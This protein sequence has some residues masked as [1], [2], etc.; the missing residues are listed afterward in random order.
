M[1]FFLKIDR[2]F[3]ILLSLRD[4]LDSSLSSSFKKNDGGKPIKRKIKSKKIIFRKPKFKSIIFLKNRDNVG[5][6]KLIILSKKKNDF[7]KFKSAN[8]PQNRDNAVIAI[9]TNIITVVISFISGNLTSDNKNL[10]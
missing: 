2:P 10:R 9:E 5:K 6:I 1:V 4:N 3:Y 7:K 8:F